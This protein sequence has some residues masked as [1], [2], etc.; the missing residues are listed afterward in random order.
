MR[1]GCDI[2]GIE[3]FTTEIIVSGVASLDLR[4]QLLVPRPFP[5]FLVSLHTGSMKIG[6]M[7][8]LV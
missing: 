8:T 1:F 5:I 3:I 6:G 4:R 7:V 2:I